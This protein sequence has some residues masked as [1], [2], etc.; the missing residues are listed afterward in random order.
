MTLIGGGPLVVAAN[1]QSALQRFDEN[2]GSKITGSQDFESCSVQCTPVQCSARLAGQVRADC[3]AWSAEKKRRSQFD[4][5]NNQL[6]VLHISISIC[7]LHICA[8]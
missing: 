1:G 5:L 4:D 2:F 8:Q 6:Y 3:Y 7:Q